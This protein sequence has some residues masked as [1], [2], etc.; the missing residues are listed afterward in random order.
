MKIVIHDYA[1]HPFQFDLSKELCKHYND[2]WH[3]YSNS[4][5]GP[6]TG[7]NIP[8]QT[9]NLVVKDINIGEVQK[10][11]FFKRF[12][13]EYK[14]GKELCSY[15]DTIKPDVIISA[16]TPLPAQYQLWQFSKKHNS[17][18]IFWLQDIISVAAK[19][20][21]SKK[22]FILGDFVSKILNIVE[23]RI[24][25][26][27]DY[28][29]TIADGFNDVLN[30]WNIKKN[31]LTIPNWSPIEE[32]KILPKEN[33]FSGIYKLQDTFNII[34]SGT[35]G[36]KHNPDLIFSSAKQL[37]EYRDIKFIVISEGQG[38]D[39]LK[40]KLNE[41]PL[42]NLEILPFQKWEIFSDV[43]S[44][45]DILL[46]ILEADAGIFSV[47]SKVWSGYCSARPSLLVVPAENLAAKITKR[48]NA[49]IIVDSY[50][51]KDIV[52][53]ILKLK[54][55]KK[56]STL[57][58]ENARRYAEENFKIESIAQKFMSIIDT[59][60]NGTN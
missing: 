35:M 32:I 55:N 52:E 48:I 18:F 10:L 38:A 53:N 58:G 41:S 4:S 31:Y 33:E 42:P 2:V 16:N 44:T 5:G 19:N 7:F 51:P 13:Q 1:G 30:Q 20:I 9:N 17:K 39:Y 15:L 11:N 14:Y 12:L 27:S 45:A 47:P 29:I 49:G 25:Q 59:Q 26:N 54:N 6:K 56:L 34:Y 46:T 22:Y 28:I 23:K 8:S 40:N 36:F 43:L 3:I 60:L 24:L 37:R 50:N 57:M 21:L